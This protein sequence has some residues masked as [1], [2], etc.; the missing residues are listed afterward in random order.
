MIRTRRIGDHRKP[1]DHSAV[2]NVVVCASRRIPAL[3]FQ[4][5]VKVAVI[6]SGFI[7]RFF[8]VSFLL[9][10]SDQW[11]KRALLL[12]F[13]GL[14]VKAVLSTRAHL[15]TSVRIP[16]PRRRFGP[17]R[18]IRAGRQRMPGRPEWRSAHC[19]PI[20]RFKSSSL[21]C[22]VS[23]SASLRRLPLQWGSEKARLP[24]LF[25]EPPYYH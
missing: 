12:T 3:G 2:D 6:R 9:G 24:R 4:D 10:L 15:K 23:K 1:A 13:L 18:R 17:S 25:Q 20:L 14:P 19:L 7:T 5:L 11:P 16:G 22:L 21:P 8:L